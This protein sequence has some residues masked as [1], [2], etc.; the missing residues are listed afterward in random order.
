MS[1]M[2]EGPFVNCVLGDLCW[3]LRKVANG[4]VLTPGELAYI[5]DVEAN[6]YKRM[7]AYGY[8]SPEESDPSLP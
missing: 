1:A 3:F 6:A 4:D 7:T 5:E 2:R 8:T